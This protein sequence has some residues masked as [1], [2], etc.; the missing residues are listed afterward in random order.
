[1]SSILEVFFKQK[2]IL[3]IN[4]VLVTIKNFSR[5]TLMETDRLNM[6]YSCRICL[7][8]DVRINLIAPCKCSGSSKWVHRHCLDRWRSTREDKA[9]SS[10]TECLA[11]YKLLCIA[12]DNCNTRCSRRMR[13]TCLLSRDFSF[14]LICTQLVI[15]FFGG[16]IWLCDS[17]KHNLAVT[18]QM[19]NHIL[20]LY[21]LLG[22]VFALTLA[23][24]SFVCMKGEC[25]PNSRYQ[26]CD[27]F[28]YPYYVPVNSPHYICCC[29]GQCA[30]CCAGSG[31]GDCCTAT[32]LGEEAL[33]IV[34]ALVVIFALIGVF[35]C[36]VMGVIYVQYVV[37]RHIKVLR[38]FSLTKEYIVADL[39][40]GGLSVEQTK[41]IYLKYSDGDIEMADESVEDGYAMLDA[42]SLVDGHTEEERRVHNNLVRLGLN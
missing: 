37:Q 14:A 33:I 10:C 25:L 38:K 31:I 19:E 21:Y 40:P 20:L 27:G 41:G 23:G 7:D 42:Q 30:S 2:Y 16:F 17:K 39:E 36:I 6:S 5:L 18:F 24:L 26:P 9:F 12:D 15:G 32:A 1:M 22:L 29:D 34:V 35:V 28:L 11:H 13:F 3:Y 4:Q 8:D